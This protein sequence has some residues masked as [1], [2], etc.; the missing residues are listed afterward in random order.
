[1]LKFTVDMLLA[2]LHLKQRQVSLM[3][4]EVD[5]MRKEH[6]LKIKK[7]ENELNYYKSYMGPRSLGDPTAQPFLGKQTIQ[8]SEGKTAIVRSSFSSSRGNL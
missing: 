5:L 6:A 3:E 2:E 4:R 7:L 8:P 1:M